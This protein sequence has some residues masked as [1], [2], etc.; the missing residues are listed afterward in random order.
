MARRLGPLEQTTHRIQGISR[1]CR[2]CSTAVTASDYGRLVDLAIG[3][4]ACGSNNVLEMV[5][6]ISARG[7]R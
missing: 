7:E 3:K 2:R 4:V 6:P 1:L 5:L